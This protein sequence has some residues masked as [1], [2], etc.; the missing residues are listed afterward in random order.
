MTVDSITAAA[1]RIQPYIR[2]T[3]VLKLEHCAGATLPDEF[4]LKLECLQISGSFK[5]RGAV[6]RVKTLAAEQLANGLVAA[7]GGNHGL[8]T[9]YMARQSGVPATIFLPTN[10]SPIKERKLKQWGAD[11]R[12][13][14][15]VWDE[16]HEAAQAFASECGAFYMHPFADDAIVSGQGTVAV[17]MLE[18]IPQTDVYIIAIGGGGLITG[19]SQVIKAA[20]PDARIIGVEPVGSP[21]LHASFQAGKVVRLPQI[22]TRVATMACGRTDEAIY[23]TSRHLVDD[24]VLIEDDD[25]QR[26]ADLLWFEFGIAADLSGAASLAALMAGAVTPKKGERIAG[27]VCGAGVDGI[28]G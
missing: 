17:E 25:M 26:A 23:E 4:Y 21:T 16:A 1:K 6:N 27:L 14:G 24:I 19:M 3:P 10:A 13:A 22:T 28:G 18:Q 7:S 9:A 5:A 15:S 20:N 12:Y 8:A 2:R 11:V